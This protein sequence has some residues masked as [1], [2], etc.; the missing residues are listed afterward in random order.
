VS[1]AGVAVQFVDLTTGQRE[2][3]L[4]LVEYHRSMVMPQ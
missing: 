2:G 4:A 1:G 3:L